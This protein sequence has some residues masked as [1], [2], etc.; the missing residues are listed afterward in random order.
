MRSPLAPP[1]RHQADAEGIY[2][3]FR[4]RQSARVFDEILDGKLWDFS[5]SRRGVGTELEFTKQCIWKL[6][7]L[8]RQKDIRSMRRA[9]ISSEGKKY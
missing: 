7:E 4:W 1:V 2:P 3:C 6:A 5:E 8:L 9:A